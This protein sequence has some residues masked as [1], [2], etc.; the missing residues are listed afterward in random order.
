MTKHMPRWTWTDDEPGGA[1]LSG[2][3]LA[4]IA[5]HWPGT[6]TNAYGVEPAG[7]VRDRL[8]AWRD[9]HVNGRGWSDI[10]YNYAID[11]AGRQW[12]LRGLD[13]VGAHSASKANPDANHE[14][15]GLLLILGDEEAPTPEMITAFSRFRADRFLA[16]YPA[17]WR[18]V[19]HQDVPGA[20]TE[21]PGRHVMRLID[22]G[23]LAG[24]PTPPEEEVLD[25]T[26][27]EIVEA[28]MNNPRAAPWFETRSANGVAR[29]AETSTK[30]RQAIRKMVEEEVRQEIDRAL[31]R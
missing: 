2:G 21:C 24:D 12:E 25:M 7:D 18:I 3:K 30:F 26:P 9:Y 20:S 28:F 1:Q 10:G 22:S 17:A 15:L 13:R 31:G 19:G 8:V 27:D 23:R 5:V 6:T 11:Q 4:G 14:W 16:R 29:A